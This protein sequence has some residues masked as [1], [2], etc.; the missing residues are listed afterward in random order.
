VAANCT[1]E[2]AAVL[3]SPD[4]GR[5]LMSSEALL[6]VDCVHF[7]LI[8]TGA[9]PQEGCM[10]P[11]ASNYEASA[12]AD[13]DS[14]RYSCPDEIHPVWGVSLR[15]RC[16]IYNIDGEVWEP[17]APDV[18]DNEVR[19]IF[20]QGR[21]LKRSSGQ[22]RFDYFDD[23]PA[24]W[25]G[26]DRACITAG[27]RLA[28]VDSDAADAK[29]KEVVPGLNVPVWIG[30]NDLATEQRCTGAGFVWVD[31]DTIS[32]AY[33][34]WLP[35][36]PDSFGCRVLPDPTGGSNA[37]L[38]DVCESGC[39]DDDSTC[40]S[41]LSHEDC[42]Q[43]TELDNV[44]ES[45]ADEDCSQPK[46][47]VCGFPCIEGIS[48]RK[49]TNMELRGV[50]GTLRML[51]FD[52][53]IVHGGGGAQLGTG[54]ALFDSQIVMEHVR[55][56]NSQQRGTGAAGIFVQGGSLD[57]KF[58]QL[59]KNQLYLAGSAG[60][61]ARL[62]A[63]VRLS[64]SRIDGNEVLQSAVDPD[65]PTTIATAIMLEE[66]SLE[67]SYSRIAYNI[68]ASAAV[69]RTS[70]VL[71][72][73]SVV[74]N[75][76][77]LRGGSALSLIDTVA[78][79]SSTA[80]VA[81]SGSTGAITAVRTTV[82]M[83]DVV[84]SRNRGDALAASGGAL[85][86]SA[87][88]SITGH[89]CTF[90]G[91]SAYASVSA[92]AILCEYSQIRLTASQLIQNRVAEQRSDSSRRNLQ[93]DSVVAITGAGGIHATG[94]TVSVL[95]SNITHNVAVN[96]NGELIGPAFS[97]GFFTRKVTDA[98]FDVSIKYSSF[99]PFVEGETVQISPGIVGGVVIGGCVQNPC[100]PGHY[101]VYESY[102]LS[103]HPCSSVTYSADGII[104]RACPSSM[105]P[106]TAL[107]GCEN[108]VGNNYSSFGVCQPCADTLVVSDDRRTCRDCGV[109]QSAMGSFDNDRTC[110][111]E[112]GFV[113]GS[114]RVHVC[115]FG[116]YEDDK[117]QAAI[118]K[119]VASLATTKQECETC[120]K[121]IT[122]DDCLVCSH[123]VSSISPGFT[124]PSLP[125]D[126]SR[127]AL[128]AMEVVT[129]FR[130]HIDMDLAIAR[131]PGCEEAPCKCAEGYSGSLCDGCADGYGMDSGSRK[132]ETC[133]GTGYTPESLGILIGILVGIP[134]LFGIA[135][136]LWKAFPLRH[137]LRCAFQPIRILITYSQITS[138][139]RI[140]SPR[141]D[142][143]HLI[144][145]RR[146]S[147]MC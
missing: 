56:T 141:F 86:L 60:L 12:I 32:E 18:P 112:S 113:N 138:Q 6:V 128:Q 11:A 26:A 81:N 108:C 51:D 110:G 4:G 146:S 129:V 144:D 34:R 91:N 72:A 140:P 116:S 71:I 139:V 100:A 94:S 43:M 143:S 42:V 30:M 121:D 16:F 87:G 101:C 96:G 20:I 119:N 130:C 79:L 102:S 2:L 106:T 117:Y 46:S 41:I 17:T 92:G 136:K 3:A 47:Y 37:T 63:S 127:R 48:S 118:D 77:G 145:A 54:L 137:L 9:T 1:E 5:Q 125:A 78:T 59:E 21:M 126:S 65:N 68:G 50:R 35:S 76:K 85:Y 24:S 13:D 124:I 10:D 33:Q 84:F 70:T 62:G 28:T 8:Q 40:I 74:K 105:G 97:N 115:F 133:E 88:S 147:E 31:G 38:T 44:A 25:Q 111:C 7:F 57:V 135:G 109:H 103:C 66:A 49:S 132:C 134:L 114:A 123:G 19:N 107:S 90:K 104:C 39:S 75:N 53:E 122:G 80:F 73:N 61:Y 99:K 23:Q 52:G 142:Q 29:V 15:S 58:S 45:W 67:C 55:V 120:P 83:D 36:Q 64:Y 14:C 95:D 131:C 82:T 93:T 27:G 98:P 22:C 69:A 89:R